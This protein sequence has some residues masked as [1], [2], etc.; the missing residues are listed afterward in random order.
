MN[1]TYLRDFAKLDELLYLT[2]NKFSRALHNDD[3][4]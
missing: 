1:Y 2:V 4:F 3:N